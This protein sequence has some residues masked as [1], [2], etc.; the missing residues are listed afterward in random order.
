MTRTPFHEQNVCEL[1]WNNN[2]MQVW[3]CIF[4]NKAEKLLSSAPF[5]H[6]NLYLA[7]IK[8]TTKE[9]SGFGKTANDER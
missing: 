8:W 4:G 7:N 5:L 6:I 3:E 1:F 2:G 9:R